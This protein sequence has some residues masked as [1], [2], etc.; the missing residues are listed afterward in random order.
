MSDSSV[1]LRERKKQ[2]TR[3]ELIDVALE[4]FTEN[5]FDATT[6]DDLCGAVEVSK[7]TFFRYFTSKEDVGMA[8]LH[9][10]WNVF[11]EE[12]ETR[13]PAGTI[14]EFLLETA[15]AALDRMGG[16]A[17]AHRLRLSRRLAARTPSMN[18]HG[19]DFC[20]RAVASA[21][22]TLADRFGI[23]NSADLRLRLVVEFAVATHRCALERWVAL[24]GRPGRKRLEAELRSAFAAMPDAL[25]VGFSVASHTGR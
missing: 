18:A 22:S 20:D 12:L 7:R 25:N 1:S 6:L 3:Q 14:L 16:D 17:W 15:F 21:V 8:P 10:F 11:G 5:G 9:D 2:R 4:M 24:R 13:S 19:L 23:A